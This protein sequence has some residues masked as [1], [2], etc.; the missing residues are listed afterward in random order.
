ML[1]N[2]AIGRGGLFSG[3]DPRHLRQSLP[4]RRKYQ[5]VVTPEAFSA[6]YWLQQK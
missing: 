1:G 5:P 2:V 3:R 4:Y 6:A